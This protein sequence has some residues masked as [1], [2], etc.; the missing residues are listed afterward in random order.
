MFL[1]NYKPLLALTPLV[2]SVT[3][4]QACNWVD[5]TGRQ[6]NKTP[7]VELDKDSLKDGDVLKKLE[8][9]SFLLSATAVDDDGTVDSYVWS[10]ASDEG[11]LQV[12]VNAIDL[13]LAGNSLKEVCEDKDNCEVLFLPNEETPGVFTVMLPKIN[14]PI[15][16]SYNLA[17]ADNDGGSTDLSVNLCIDSVNESPVVANDHYA[18]VEG[19]ALVVKSSEGN[20]LL[21]N[22][23]D[24]K[25][26]RN[27]DLKV[28]G[29]VS[30][31]GPKHGQDFSLQADGSFSYSISPLTAFTQKEDEFV[32]QV[33]DGENVT[34]GTVKLD[35]SVKDDPPKIVGFIPDISA[36]VGISILTV[37]VSGKFYD[38]EG[39]KMDYTATGLPAGISLSKKGVISGAAKA[40]NKLGKH[41][42]VVSASDG[43]NSISQSPFNINLL[44]NKPPQ[45]KGQLKDQ[46]ATEAVKFSVS[47]TGFFS[48]P[49]GS[50]LT[51]RASGLPASLKMSN[52]GIISGTPKANEI[53]AYTVSAIASDGFSESKM[54]FKLAVKANKVPVRVKNIPNQFAPIGKAFSFNSAP[55][56]SDPEGDALSYSAVGLPASGNLSINKKSGVISG[57]PNELDATASISG[58]AVT[59]TAT[60]GRG[61]VKA[62][63]LLSIF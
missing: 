17:I 10:N 40:S 11:A 12:C 1:T 2:I 23:S 42:V 36:E 58:N 28:L 52:L 39:I 62:T 60:D 3:L 15:G 9:D 54:T 34:E 41:S 33:T 55:Y 6:G 44:A 45:L 57:T 48:D 50:A 47:V 37:D 29:V 53:G 20:G 51:F 24:D 59:L 5:S 22:D 27:Q 13:A 38:P 4:L 30:G 26:I 16:V 61:V 7:K 19:S 8:E 56:F 32:Y 31:K 46:S 35:L 25:D 14:K 63:F 21:S 18:V 49:E 43:A